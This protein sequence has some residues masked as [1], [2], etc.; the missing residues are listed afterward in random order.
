MR[1]GG[2]LQDSPPLFAQSQTFNIASPNWNE[3]VEADIFLTDEKKREKTDILLD[4]I[5]PDATR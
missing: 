5:G 3:E 4:Y 2:R 1:G